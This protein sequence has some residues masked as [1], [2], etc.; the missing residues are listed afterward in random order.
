MDARLTNVESLQCRSDDPNQSAVSLI[1]VI[2]I[3][4]SVRT[5]STIVRSSSERLNRKIDQ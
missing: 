2:R 5:A 3:Y 4:E 1:G